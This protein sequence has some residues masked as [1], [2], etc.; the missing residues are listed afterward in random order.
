MRLQRPRLCTPLAVLCS[1]KAV[2]EGPQKDRRRRAH[3]REAETKEETTIPD[4]GIS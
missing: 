2:G 4:E 1:E 3:G